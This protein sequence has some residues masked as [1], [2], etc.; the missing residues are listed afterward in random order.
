MHAFALVCMLLAGTGWAGAAEI[1]AFISTAIKAATDEV[2]P[3][4]ERANGHTIR[5]SYA[6]SGALI[7]R[8]ERGEPVA[9]TFM[10][11]SRFPANIGGVR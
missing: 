9:G 4:F 5:A 10:S 8:F 3:P 11:A 6:P 7:P 1:N 2:L